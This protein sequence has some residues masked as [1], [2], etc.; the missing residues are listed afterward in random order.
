MK[1]KRVEV[2]KLEKRLKAESQ[3]SAENAELNSKI[4][5]LERDLASSRQKHSEEK[6]RWNEETQ[7]FNETKRNL[8]QEISFTNGEVER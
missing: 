7:K 4:E 1:D 5:Q 2:K 6:Q 3:S 8:Q